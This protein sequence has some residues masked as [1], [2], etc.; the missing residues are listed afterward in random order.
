[1]DMQLSATLG[2]VSRSSTSGVPASIRIHGLNYWFGKGETRTPA[3]TEVSLEVG[4]GE[5]VILTG[6]SGS[7]KTTLLTIIGALRRPDLGWVKVLGRDLSKANEA[8][9]VEFRRQIGFIFQRHNLFHSLTAIENVRM[10]TALKSLSTTEM[11]QR[12]V[13]LLTRMGLGERLH[14]LPSNLSG[15]QSQRVAIARALVN[16]PPLVLAD[17]PTASLDAESGQEVLKVLRELAAGPVK[18]TVLIVTHDQR[19]LE[20]ADRI[21]NLVGGRIVSNVMPQIS[22]KICKALQSIEQLSAFSPSMLALFADH[23]TVENYPPGKV[24]NVE[25]GEGDRLF[26]IGDGEAEE[27]HDHQVTRTLKQGD[28]FGTISALFHNTL[29]S[30]IRARTP[31]EVYVMTKASLERAMEQDKALE[32]RVMLD[33]MNRQ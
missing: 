26:V 7:G 1:M 27:L 2:P 6:P 28:F 23:M 4:Q 31:L 3:L 8:D 9:I 10:A 32:E 30:T 29:S 24:L 18:S 16:D 14:H 13:A 15:G 11:N 25:G 20:R 12:A 21:V 19:V 17:E 33:L 22:I 5:V